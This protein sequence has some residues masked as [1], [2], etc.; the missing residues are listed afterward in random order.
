MTANDGH[1]R[2]RRAGLKAAVG[3]R[4]PAS[5]DAKILDDAVVAT[6]DHRID[7]ARSRFGS[8]CVMTREH[9]TG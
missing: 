1:F 9:A 4:P 5:Q 6:D 3:T 8:P 7:E 2:C